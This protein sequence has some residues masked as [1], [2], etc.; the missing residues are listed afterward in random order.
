M[1][2]RTKQWVQGLAVAIAVLFAASGRPA[3][4]GL[5]YTT[6]FKSHPVYGTTPKSIVQ[7]MN[8]HPIPDPDD[9]AALANI[10]HAHKLNVTTRSSGSGCAVSSV[11]FTWNFVITLPKAMEQAKMSAATVGM[12][13][14]FVAKAKW[15]ELHRREIFLAC[16]ASFVP[17]AERLTAPTCFGLKAKVRRYID[18]Q[19]A[20]CMK[21]QREFGRADRASIAN[22]SLM[23]AGLGR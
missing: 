17:A 8:S 1:H 16:G 18:Q 5:R 15:H 9:G 20:L 7:Y 13:N 12:W 10:T 3:E 4:A 19:Y 14:E 2:C 11:D 22:L 6:V 21:K 23:R